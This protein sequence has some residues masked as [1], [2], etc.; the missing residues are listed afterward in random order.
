MDGTENP[1]A[2]RRDVGLR[3]WPIDLGIGVRGNHYR[4]AD[5]PTQYGPAS[6]A[7]FPVRCGFLHALPIEGPGETAEN[8]R[9][10]AVFIGAA[11]AAARA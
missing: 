6:C 8:W 4:A 7:K 5:R 3:E 11:D 2:V 9:C 10:R 1:L